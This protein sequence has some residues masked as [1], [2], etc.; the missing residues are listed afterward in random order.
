MVWFTICWFWR[1]C[2]A[3]GEMACGLVATGWNW[4]FTQ[5]SVLSWSRTLQRTNDPWRG[6][7]RRR[8]AG[9]CRRSQR[10]IARLRLS[11]YPGPGSRCQSPKWGQMV[12]FMQV[13][14]A[15]P[16]IGLKPVKM[17]WFAETGLQWNFRFEM[18]AVRA[19]ANGMEIEFTEP[20]A[21]GGRRN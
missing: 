2:K 21:D 16:A 4:Q 19:T 12:L 20:I 14:L 1:Y 15:I 8:Q 7:P 11:F 10:P 17:V 3:Q 18:L 13:V 9:I 5:H 6:H